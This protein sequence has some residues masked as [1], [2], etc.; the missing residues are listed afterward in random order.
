MFYDDSRA[1]RQHLSIQQETDYVHVRKRC[2]CGS[3]VTARQLDQYGRCA[4]CE[5]VARIAA[6]HV[7][8][9]TAA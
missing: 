9:E 7:A 3:I 5:K 8:R 6:L 4:T 1:E 2:G